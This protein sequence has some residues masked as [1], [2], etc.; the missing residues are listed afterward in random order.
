MTGWWNESALVDTCSVQQAVATMDVPYAYF[1]IVNNEDKDEGNFVFE[2]VES[3]SSE[4]SFLSSVLLLMN[5]LNLPSDLLNDNES[6]IS[7]LTTASRT[8]QSQR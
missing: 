3:T 5:P 2:A 4:P 1:L 6:F 8:H 7:Q